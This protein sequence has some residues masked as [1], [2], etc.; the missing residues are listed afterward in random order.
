MGLYILYL[1]LLSL[2]LRKMH[3]SLLSSSLILLASG[4]FA[5]AIQ[6]K[7]RWWVTHGLW[8]LYTSSGVTACKLLV[9][10]WFSKYTAYDTPSP[11]NCLGNFFAL[12]RFLAMSSVATQFFTHLFYKNFENSKISEKKWKSKKY[13]F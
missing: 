4:I 1:I 10:Q 3:F 2:Y 7:T 5:Y 13:V 11:Q 8:P 12:S 9:G 6:S